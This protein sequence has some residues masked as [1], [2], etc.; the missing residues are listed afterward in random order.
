MN[1]IDYG[2]ITTVEPT[3]IEKDQGYRICECGKNVHLLQAGFEC[4]HI[5]C[6]EC[7]YSV[8]DREQF[9]K[10]HVGSEFLSK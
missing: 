9:F 3:D 1:S 2:K 10:F 6:S 8:V 7:G 4:R 5:K